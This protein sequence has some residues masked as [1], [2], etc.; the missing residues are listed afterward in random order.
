MEEL[1]PWLVLLIFSKYSVLYCHDIFQYFFDIWFVSLLSKE[2][3]LIW[4][5]QIIDAEYLQQGSTI[6]FYIVIIF[7]SL[8]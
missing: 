8:S 3:L 2:D 7:L 5:V 4:K 6:L 1:Y